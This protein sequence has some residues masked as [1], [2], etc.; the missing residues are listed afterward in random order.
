M[1][2]VEE[3]GKHACQ[4]AGC[5]GDPTTTLARAHTAL[6]RL[7]W[8]T[9]EKQRRMTAAFEAIKLGW[10][11]ITKVAEITGLSRTTI[12]QGMRELESETKLAGRIR[13]KGAGRPRVEKKRRRPGA[14]AQAVDAG[15]D[16]R[17]SDDRDQVGPQEHA[18]AEPGTGT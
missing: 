10:G 14:H 3:T 12:R 1:D 13:S 15:P 17:R 6:N 2:V 7:I 4:C 8:R 18:Q 5:R 9:D 16:R 11:G